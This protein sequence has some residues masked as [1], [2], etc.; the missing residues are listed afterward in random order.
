MAD[1]VVKLVELCLEM[2]GVFLVTR[3]DLFPQALNS[4][5]LRSESLPLFWGLRRGEV[6]WKELRAPNGQWPCWGEVRAKKYEKIEWKLSQ[7]VTRGGGPGVGRGAR[8]GFE[9]PS[10][11][12][13]PLS[14]TGKNNETST[15]GARRGAR[16]GATESL[17]SACLIGACRCL[18]MLCS[19]SSRE[20]PP[21]ASQRTS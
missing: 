4:S 19:S 14:A 3:F 9:G 15:C 13:K 11:G 8:N 7:F 21:A 16:R 12:A 1:K 2:F 20:G 17:A 5:S 6:T 18:D 10:G